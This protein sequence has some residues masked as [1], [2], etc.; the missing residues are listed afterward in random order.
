MRRVDYNWNVNQIFVLSSLHHLMF[1]CIIIDVTL[2]WWEPVPTKS[3]N[4]FR[5]YSGYM[6]GVCIISGDFKWLSKTLRTG[7]V[8]IDVIPALAL[9]YNTHTCIQYIFEHKMRSFLAFR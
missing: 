2:Q 4:F 1:I 6:I 9:T 3:N 7:F 8:R 5:L